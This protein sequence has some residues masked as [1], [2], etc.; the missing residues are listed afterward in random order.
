MPNSLET[1]FATMNEKI[2]DLEKQNTKEHESIFKKLDLIDT[3][4]DSAKEAIETKALSDM[5]KF[6]KQ[7]DWN[8]M[9][10]R[11]VNLEKFKWQI[12]TAIAVL[13]LLANLF[14]KQIINKF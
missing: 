12:A 1:R 3:K 6:V 4:L 14:G 5:E 13:T 8:D 7:R 9:N 10:I 11:V 2:F